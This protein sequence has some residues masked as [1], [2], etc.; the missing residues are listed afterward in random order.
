MRRDGERWLP[1]WIGPAE[2]TALA[3]ALESAESPRPFTYKLAASL[4]QAAGGRLTEVRI[5]RLTGCGGV[6]MAGDMALPAP[7]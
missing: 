2:V 5:T 3:L 1:I 6:P 4:L 7:G